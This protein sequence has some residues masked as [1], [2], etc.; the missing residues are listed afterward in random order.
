MTLVRSFIVVV[1]F[2]VGL[3]GC[4]PEFDD[5]GTRIEARRVIAIQ[6][7]PAEVDLRLVTASGETNLEA[8]VAD[9]LDRAADAVAWTLCI[10]RKP[11]SE[12]GP[13]SKRCLESP[14]PGPDIAIELG[15]GAT[16]PATL[17]E[18]ACQLFGPERPDPEP[19]EPAGRPVDPDPT[20]GFYQPV[21]AW[22][23]DEVVVGG[24]RIT[25]GLFNVAPTV[26]TDFTSRYQLNEN[27]AIER[28]EL[29]ASDGSITALEEGVVS[30]VRAGESYTVRAVFP[31]CPTEPDCGDGI[32]S[33]GETT[34]DAFPELSFCPEDCETPRGCG[35]A[36]TY[37]VYDPETARVETRRESP[38][39]SWFA[40][41]GSFSSERTGDTGALEESRV[42]SNGWKAPDPGPARIWAVLR[43]DRGGVA[44]FQA[45]LAVED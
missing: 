8:I 16:V 44:T 36:E 33:S 26:S 31:S 35:G 15:R 32:C 41:G 21:L 10:D 28:L 12:L 7:S 22:L 34:S 13:V 43:D 18:L 14:S 17:P 30:S 5:D 42:S 11:L 39:V 27:P 9:G 4:I 19:G 6:A 38:I 20:G 3:A 37:V 2:T 23:D 29:V 25:C 1:P 24:V 45:N 40:T